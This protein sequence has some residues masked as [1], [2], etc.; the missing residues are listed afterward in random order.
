MKTVRICAHAKLNL[1]LAVGPKRRDGYHEIATLLTA[2]SLH[3]TLTFA[4]R[5]RGFALAVDGP[6]ARGVPRAGAN[7]VLQAARAL[8]A[9][10][11]VTRGATIRLTKRVPHGAGLGGGSSDAAATLRGLLGLWGRRLPRAR[12]LAFAARLGSDVPFFLVRSP[13]FAHGRGEILEELPPFRPPLQLVVVVPPVRVATAWAYRQY[14][15]P[16]SRLTRRRRLATLVPLRTEVVARSKV[17]HNF[18][19]DL[20]NAVLPRVPPVRE[21]LA[22]LRAGGAIEARMTGSGSAVFG[23]VVAPRARERVAVQLRMQGYKVYVA[24]SIRAGSRPCR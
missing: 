15:I 7:L 20:E 2:I 11:G 6:E 4:P 18:F 19:N 12:L 24:R 13:A 1:R 14:T 16:K 23:L 10:L 9:E 22:A 3:D 17:K 5:A 8:Q 21:A